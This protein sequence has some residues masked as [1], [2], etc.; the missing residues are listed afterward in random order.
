MGTI[1]KARTIKFKGIDCILIVNHTFRAPVCEDR[2]YNRKVMSI[3]NN[4]KFFMYRGL[5]S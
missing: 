4:N 3:S 2:M 5:H 1:V